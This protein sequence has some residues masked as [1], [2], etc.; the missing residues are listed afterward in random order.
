MGQ[1]EL[2]WRAVS[3]LGLYF[4][5]FLYTVEVMFETAVFQ[6]MNEMNSTDIFDILYLLQWNY[7]W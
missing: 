4:F 6:W 3:R 7:M 5:Y 1:N 2:Q